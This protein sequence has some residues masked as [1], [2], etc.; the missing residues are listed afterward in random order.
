MDND[1]L[2]LDASPLVHFARADQLGALRDVVKNFE[3]VTTKA[4]LGELRKGSSAIRRSVPPLSLN[5]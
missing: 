2:V 3:C 5:G 1:V 4:V